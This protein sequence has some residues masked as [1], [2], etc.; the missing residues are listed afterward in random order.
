MTKARLPLVLPPLPGESLSGW[1]LAIADAYGLPWPNLLRSLDLA[2][3]RKLRRLSI[4]PPAEWLGQLAGVTGLDAGWMRS[5]MTLGTLARDL[6]PLV[7]ASKACPDC[8]VET[9]PGRWRPVEWLADLAPWTFQCVR[10]ACAEARQGSLDARQVQRM[11]RDLGRFSRHVRSA[12]PNRA[13]RAFSGVPLRL[14]SALDMVR[15]VNGRMRLHSSMGSDGHVVFEVLDVPD[16]TRSVHKLPARR[17]DS[18]AGSAWFVWH[19]LTAPMEAFWRNMRCRDASAAYDVLAAVFDPGQI[20]IVSPRWDFAMSLSRIAANAVTGSEAE[21]VQAGKVAGAARLC[22]AGRNPRLA[23]HR[24]G[25]LPLNPVPSG[26]RL[27][28]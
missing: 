5:V 9:P 25:D 7:D 2:V 27:G 28:S 17:R 23:M 11:D 12:A 1:V 3:P 21:A 26:N 4:A 8:P 16:A 6:I 22:V 15:E 13:G 10:P 19:V 24:L 14:A 20:G 18:R